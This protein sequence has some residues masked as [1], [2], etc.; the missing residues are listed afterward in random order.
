MGDVIENVGISLSIITWSKTWE[1]PVSDLTANILFSITWPMPCYWKHG[2]FPV[3]KN[4]GNSL[5]IITWR[6]CPSRRVFLLLRTFSV[7][8]M[9]G[10]PVCDLSQ[11]GGWRVCEYMHA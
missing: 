9:H 4:M 10:V 3:N 5:M 2:K 6:F 11:K 7:V 1:F 8:G